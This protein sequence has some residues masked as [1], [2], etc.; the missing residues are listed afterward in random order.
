MGELF[1]GKCYQVLVWKNFV[2]VRV[3]S[4]VWK[5]F[6]M[7]SDIRFWYERIFLW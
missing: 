3:I 4:F 2:M 6:V 5:N 7:V 1:D